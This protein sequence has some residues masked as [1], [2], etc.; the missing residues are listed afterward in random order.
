MRG[1]HF[2]KQKSLYGLY[3]LPNR[4]LIWLPTQ[5]SLK[6][7]GKM[8]GPGRE[9]DLSGTRTD[10]IEREEKRA[11]DPLVPLRNLYIIEIL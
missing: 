7:D 1:V 10:Q 5:K 9:I 4:S 3:G 2:D 6:Q 11:R 8:D